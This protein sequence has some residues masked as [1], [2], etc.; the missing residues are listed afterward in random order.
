MAVVFSPGLSRQVVDTD[1]SGRLADTKTAVFAG[2][3]QLLPVMSDADD[4]LSWDCQS[5]EVCLERRGSSG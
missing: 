2:N 1:V 5:F 4:R 3:F